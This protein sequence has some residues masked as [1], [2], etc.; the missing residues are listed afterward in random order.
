MLSPA[1]LARTKPVPSPLADSADPPATPSSAS[2]QRWP[3]PCGW[4]VLPPVAEVPRL[5]LRFALAAARRSTIAS[6]PVVPAWKAGPEI[7]FV[8]SCPS[9]KP[10]KT[11]SQVPIRVTL[12]AV[13]VLVGQRP[14]S[15]RSEHKE[16]SATRHV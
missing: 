8:P 12:Y 14:A 11:A 9:Y 13:T 10:G 3:P 7:C 15:R 1:G 6:I 16:R 4:F 2:T 5:A